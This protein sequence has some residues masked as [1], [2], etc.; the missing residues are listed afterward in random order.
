MIH[1]L[2]EDNVLGSQWHAHDFGGGVLNL[3]G[4][5]HHKNYPNFNNDD[6]DFLFFSWLE[7]LTRFV[8]FYKNI[9]NLIE[10]NTFIN[11]NN[12]IY[13]N[14]SFEEP[15]LILRL[16]DINNI[17]LPNNELNYLLFNIAIFHMNNVKIMARKLL[18]ES[19]YNSFF[20]CLTVT[21]F[22]DEFII[23]N[24]YVSKIENMR[25]LDES[26]RKSDEIEIIKK[27][28]SKLNLQFSYDIFEKTWFDKIVN[29]DMK[30]I[31]IV[32][33]SYISKLKGNF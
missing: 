12:L 17:N 15:E 33:K 11:F 19:S 9:F 10:K 3:D 20:I 18:P 24:F 29:Q 4:T 8:M 26:F 13:Y 2:N 14:G 7:Y 16:D 27:I 31:Y 30:R 23:P 1:R 22:E 28:L 32:E 6:R 21:D 25:F 5:L